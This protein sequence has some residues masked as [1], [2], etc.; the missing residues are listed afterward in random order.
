MDT[1]QHIRDGLEEI[2]VIV[3]RLNNLIQNGEPPW[4]DIISTLPTNSTP[5]HPDL[6]KRKWNWWPI[7]HPND[8]A[9]I[10]IHHTMSHSPEATARFCTGPKRYPSIQYHLWVSQADGCP[11]TLCAPLSWM[12]WHDHTGA[13]PSTISVGMAGHL[14]KVRPP[15]EQIQATALLVAYLMKEYDIPLAQVKG[16]RDRYPTDCPGWTATG[17][18]RPSGNWRNDF[19]HAVHAQLKT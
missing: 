19:Y 6:V 14:H 9:G 16:H 8:V 1:N 2:Q 13:K 10:T 18:S 5:S 15:D 17:R 3:H 11:I 7:R 4:Q 12:I